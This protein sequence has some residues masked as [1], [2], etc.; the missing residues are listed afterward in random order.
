[1]ATKLGEIQATMTSNIKQDQ[2]VKA[3]FRVNWT[4]KSKEVSFKPAV[5]LK[6]NEKIRITIEKI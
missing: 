5:D 3:L 4:D 2:E 1:M 6:A